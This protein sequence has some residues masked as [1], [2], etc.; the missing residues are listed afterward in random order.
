VYRDIIKV[1]CSPTNAQVIVLKSI[2]KCTLKTAPTRFG[3]V[4]PS[5]GNPFS[6]LAKV[7]VVKL[8][9]YGTSVCD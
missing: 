3:A 6:V 1:C 2:L 4:T 7:T 8:A 9:I 5:S